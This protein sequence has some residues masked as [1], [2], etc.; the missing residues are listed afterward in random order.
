MLTHDNNANDRQDFADLDSLLD[1]PV[2]TMVPDHPERLD[3]YE[4]VSARFLRAFESFTARKR[5]RAVDEVILAEFGPSR[6]S[7]SRHFAKQVET[8]VDDEALIE[9][10]VVFV[11]INPKMLV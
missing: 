2:P 4:D 11:S 8:H 6:L 1:M 10:P 5:E 9:K 3:E 7:N